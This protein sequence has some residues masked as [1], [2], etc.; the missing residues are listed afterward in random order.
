MKGIMFNKKYGLESAVLNGNKTRTWRE[1]KQPRYEVG[2]I[3]AIKQC[4][5]HIMIYDL[6]SDLSKYID[7][8]I[9]YRGQ[10]GWKNKMFV[11]NELMP[12]H[13]RITSV[14]KCKLQEITEEECIKEGVNSYKQGKETYYNCDGIYYNR[15]QGLLKPFKTAKEVFFNLIEKLN[16]RGYW[17]MNPDGYAY[18][19]ELVR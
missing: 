15:K 18:E 11:K 19:F 9:L 16:G 12:H 8:I 2:E 3:V 7:S 4:Y 5:K 17:T 13:I 1:D 6:T 10:A 14:K